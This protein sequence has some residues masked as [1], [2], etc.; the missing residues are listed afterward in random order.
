MES[1]SVS[2]RLRD[3]LGDTACDIL[4]GPFDATCHRVVYGAAPA[5]G[6]IENLSVTGSRPLSSAE[7]TAL[8]QSLS[9]DATW[10]WDLITRHRPVP[11]VLFELVLGDLR[12][13]FVLDRRGM[14]LGLLRDR[15]IHARDL[16]TGSPGA[17]ALAQI[18]ESSDSTHGS[19]AK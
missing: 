8:R 12:A 7:V 1:I 19:E 11:E 2:S 3:L 15:T 5:A 14:K 6:R 10:R 9:D 13:V 16:N 17:R 4:N 18:V